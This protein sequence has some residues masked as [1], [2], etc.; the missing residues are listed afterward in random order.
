M[1]NALVL[2]PIHVDHVAEAICVALDNERVDVRGAVGVRE[3]RRLIGWAEKGSAVDH[4]DSQA[5]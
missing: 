1:A 5:H 4:V 3:M 2:P